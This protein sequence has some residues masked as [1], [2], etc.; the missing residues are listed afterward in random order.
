MTTT[1]AG[2]LAVPHAGVGG[3]GDTARAIDARRYCSTPRGHRGA[4]SAASSRGHTPGSIRARR[5]APMMPRLSRSFA[6]VLLALL[7]PVAGHRRAR[8]STCRTSSWSDFAPGQLRLMARRFTR[9][10]ARR[11]VRSSPPSAICTWSSCRADCRLAQAIEQYRSSPD[12]LYVEPN[13]VVTLQAMPNDPRF[14]AGDLWGLDMRSRSS[15]DADIDAPEAWDI[16]TGQPRTS[17]WRSSTPASTTPTRTWPPTC[18]ATRRTATPT[19]STTT[20]TGSSTTAT[21][22]RPSTATPT[23]WTTT[24]TARTWPGP[25]A[26]SATTA[27]AWSASTGTSG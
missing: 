23:R 13:H 24:P 8:R 1:K 19:A 9:P 6:I 16:T 27:S 21:A 14:V 26:P 15:S 20:A 22:S 11:S 12:V 3:P 25:S 18:S 7:W 5:R 17:S 4:G 10:P 2:D